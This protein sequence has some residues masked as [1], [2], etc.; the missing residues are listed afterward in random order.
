M[1]LRLLACTAIVLA[2]MTAASAAQDKPTPPPIT[3]G[4]GNIKRTL[5]QKFEVPNSNM[6]TVI[7]IAEIVPNATIGRHTHF[8]VEAGY[9]LEGEL[10]LMVAGQ[11]DKTLKAGD[12]YQIAAGVP[13]DGKAGPNGAKAIATYV[14]EKG[15]PLATPA[16]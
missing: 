3:Q 8:G 1:K 4:A 14:V 13:H 10:V 5:L 2:A 15:K 6:E 9:V 16:P 11:P 7:G 12:S